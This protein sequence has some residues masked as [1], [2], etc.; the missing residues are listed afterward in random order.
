MSHSYK[1]EYPQPL[2]DNDCIL[3]KLSNDK[4]LGICQTWFPALLEFFYCRNEGESRVLIKSHNK[5][6]NVIL[7]QTRLEYYQPLVDNGCIVTK[8]INDKVLRIYHTW[9]PKLLEFF[10]IVQM[11]KKGSFIKD[12]LG[13][14]EYDTLIN[15]NIPNHQWIMIVYYLNYSMTRCWGFVKLGP[16]SLWSI[17]SQSK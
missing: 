6:M 17:F 14:F 8:L 4:M 12:L 13:N 9:F 7:L 11:R 2:V 16:L 15:Y 5:N 1:L 10:L 3:T